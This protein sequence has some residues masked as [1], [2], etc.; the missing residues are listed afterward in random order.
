MKKYLFTAVGA[1]LGLCAGFTLCYICLV[2]P[3]HEGKAEASARKQISH[4]EKTTIAVTSDGSLYLAGERVD[5]NQLTARLKELGPQQ[6]VM[7]RVDRGTDL[8]HLVQ[9]CDACMS[10]G[11]EAEGQRAGFCTETEGSALG[12]LKLPD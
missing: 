11:W 7:I 4:Q 12:L 9:V 3:R 10:L 8:K 1:C 6:P 2:L 5:V